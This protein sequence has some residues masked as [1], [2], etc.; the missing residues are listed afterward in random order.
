MI[1]DAHCHIF[2]KTWLPLWFQETLSGILSRRFGMPIEQLR[3]LRRKSLDSTGD[4]M[5]TTMDKIGIDKAIVCM[6]DLELT[7]AKGEAITPVE[8]VNRLAS[9]MVKRPSG[10]SLSGCRSRPTQEQCN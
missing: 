7:A 5:V 8:D 9:E 1:V 2:D 3:E 6:S 4:I 10:Q